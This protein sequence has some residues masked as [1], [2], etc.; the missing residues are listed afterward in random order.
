MKIE[1]SPRI[2]IFDFA[3]NPWNA[4]SNFSFSKSVTCTREH[5]R[6]RTGETNNRRSEGPTVLQHQDMFVLGLE[7][8]SEG[9][10]HLNLYD[11]L[12]SKTQKGGEEM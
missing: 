1:I 12:K 8:Q 2:I 5:E 11:H 4:G 3:S 10:A 7:C 9:S 6:Q